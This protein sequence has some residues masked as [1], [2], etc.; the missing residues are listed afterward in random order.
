VRAQIFALLAALACLA[1]PA[2]AADLPADASGWYVPGRAEVR[3]GALA[4][5]WG[6]ERGSV[7]VNG[8]I[9]LPKGSRGLSP[10]IDMLTPR[11]KFGGMYNAA[12]KTNFGY[13][14]VMWT[15]PVGPRV[16]LE[17][18]LG[19]VVHDG[20]LNGPDPGLASLGCRALGHA[21]INLGYRLDEHWSVMVSYDHASNGKSISKCPTNQSL[22]LVGG[23]IGYA[24]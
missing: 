13:A 18:Y 14:D 5:V 1:V 16:F 19:V 7:D 23:R 9:V 15:F 2:Q 17:P 3:V 10:V 20:Q 24:F 21:G 4:S 12:G 22:N 6:P 8:E 11:F